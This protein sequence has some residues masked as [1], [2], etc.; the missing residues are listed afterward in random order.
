MKKSQKNFNGRSKVEKKQEWNNKE[1]RDSEGLKVMK[2]KKHNLLQQIWNDSGTEVS[3]IIIIASY[4]SENSHAANSSYFVW[5]YV[6]RGL[7]V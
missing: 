1:P 5:K 3:A 4:F 2:Q 6:P 7:C